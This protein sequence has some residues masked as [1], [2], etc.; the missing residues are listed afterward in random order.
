MLRRHPVVKMG[1]LRPTRLL[2]RL[3][4]RYMEMMMISMSKK[5][6]VKMDQLEFENKLVLEIYKSFAASRVYNTTT[7]V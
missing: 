1:W 7:D 2:A 4:D 6:P 3:R 5:Q